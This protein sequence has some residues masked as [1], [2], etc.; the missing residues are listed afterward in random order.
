MKLT[1]PQKG[2]LKRKSQT[3]SVWTSRTLQNAGLYIT[4]ELPPQEM[5][6]IQNHCSLSVDNK[7]LY[8]AQPATKGGEVS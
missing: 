5:I 4:A 6:D 2:F 7:F 3:Y 8:S 1:I